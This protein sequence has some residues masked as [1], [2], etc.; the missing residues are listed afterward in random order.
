[1]TESDLRVLAEAFRMDV[2]MPPSGDFSSP[3]WPGSGFLGDRAA[4]VAVAD[5][6]MKWF[7]ASDMTRGRNSRFGLVGVTRDVY[8]SPLGGV[9]L[10]LF[11]TATDEVVSA[12]VSDPA[13]NYVLSTPFYPDAH[14]VVSYKAGSPDVFGS[15]INTLIAG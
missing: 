14:Y 2:E 6:N 9:T 5:P 10:K 15:S 3:W 8:G 7:E 12:V 1:V 13:G 11:R 4:D